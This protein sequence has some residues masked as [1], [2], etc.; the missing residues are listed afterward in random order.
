MIVC[1]YCGN[2]DY[3]TAIITRNE[4]FYLYQLKRKN[5]LLRLN[6]CNVTRCPLSFRKKSTRFRHSRIVKG[7][8]RNISPFVSKVRYACLVL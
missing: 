6:G 5:R 8:V 7:K 4:R 3:H 2:L 1:D